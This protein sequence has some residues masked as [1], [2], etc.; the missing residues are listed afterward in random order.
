M[1]EN[2]FGDILVDLSPDS[3][4]E[5]LQSLVASL[6]VGLNEEEQKDILQAALTTQKKSR[7]LIDMVGH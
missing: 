4:K 5:I 3:K 7:E 6:L 1:G 2:K